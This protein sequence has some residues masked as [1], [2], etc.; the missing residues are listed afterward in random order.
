MFSRCTCARS[1]ARGTSSGAIGVGGRAIPPLPTPPTEAR[2]NAT[3]TTTE[4]FTPALLCSRKICP[5]PHDLEKWGNRRVDSGHSF[6]G[7]SA[8]WGRKRK[9]R[10]V[11][12]VTSEP[13][14]S[15][16]QF[17]LSISKLFLN[18]VLINKANHELYF[19]RN[20]Y[21]DCRFPTVP[22]SIFLPPDPGR[23]KLLSY[24]RET[25][26]GTACVCVGI[27]IHQINPIKIN[28]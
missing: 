19:L 3:N 22:P 10:K 24:D 5:P 13:I 6:A 26:T 27:E 17:S 18:K 4:T 9:G 14:N 21:S 11:P 12:V 23:E 2:Y 1:W 16:M 8:F 28:V 20:V 15:T 25:G 7:I